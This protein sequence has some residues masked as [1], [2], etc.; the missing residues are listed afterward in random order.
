MK[1]LQLDHV[2]LLVADLDASHRFYHGMLKCDEMPRPAFDFPG[3]WYRLGPQQELHLIGG[4]TSEVQ[5]ARRGAHFALLVDDIEAWHAHL[6][7]TGVKFE[8]PKNRPD[9]A[10]QIF[11]PDPDGYWVELCQSPPGN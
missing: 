6:K 1:C 5:S 9:G 7:E 10:I 3:A 8:P 11:L 4:R 2:A